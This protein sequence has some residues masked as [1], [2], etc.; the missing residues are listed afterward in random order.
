[1]PLKSPFPSLTIPDCS[2]ATYLFTSPSHPLPNEPLYI[3]ADAPSNF[4]TYH[5]YRLF[6]QRL[7]LG[8]QRH[9]FKPGDRLLLYS[10]N[11]IFFPVV[12]MGTL[13]AGGIFSGANP[14][15]VA[16]EVAYQLKDSG[17]TFC[18]VAAGSLQTGLDAAAEIGFSKSNI[19]VFDADPKG[20]SVDGLKHWSSLLAPEGEAQAFEWD[21]HTRPG[22]SD[23]TAVLNY[24]SGTTG[25]PKGVE[26]THKNYVANCMQAKSNFDR[27][28]TDEPRSEDRWLAFLPMYHAMGQTF[29]VVH[30]P[31][32]KGKCYVMPKFEFEKTMDGIQKFRITYLLTAPPVI[33]ATAKH[34]D[35]R[36]GKWDLSSLVHVLTGAAP[37]GREASKEFESLDFGKRERRKEVNVKQGWG[38]TECTCTI[39]AFDPLMRSDTPSVG[40]PMSNVELRFM[41]DEGTAEV[42]PGERG[43]VWIKAPNV[44]KGYWRNEKATRETLTPDRWLKSGD[45]GYYDEN[46]LVYIVDRKK[47]L[48]KSH[49]HQ[50][51]PA[52]LEAL[53][54]D[55]PAVADAAVIGVPY[56][57]DEAPRAYVVLNANAKATE[58]EIVLFVEKRVARHK[59]LFGGVRFVDQIPKN[60]SGKIL[61]KMLR[62]KA[63]KE[64]GS[65]RARL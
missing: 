9:G 59:R 4:T 32:T 33:V 29:Y 14:G 6:S 15:Y 1:M 44:M 12:I 21:P 63:A 56:R 48:I 60:P 27:R 61:R 17:A 39:T 42:P 19:F 5:T 53:L 55:H 37:L 10:G 31:L 23:K 43:E 49:G 25:L 7:A 24:S 13:M 22:E 28:W 45:I 52:E 34:P 50:V 58:K 2:V 38:M 26:I 65:S 30:I 62:E 41:N 35:V 18:F 36:R 54:L 51:A 46:G 11:N 40:Q 3:D 20:D 8:L 64:D 57:E 16:R 47:E